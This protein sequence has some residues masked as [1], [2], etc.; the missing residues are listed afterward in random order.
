MKKITVLCFIGLVGAAAPFVTASAGVADLVKKCNSCHGEDGNS[1]YEEVPNIGG[2]SV[3]YI[4]DTMVAYQNNERPGKKF[5]PDDG[6][7]SDMNAVAEK[8][9]EAD[10][11]ALA[12]HYAAKPFVPHLQQVDAEMAAKGQKTFK[13]LCEKCHS[14]GGTVAD[15][16]SGIL[17]G[18]WKKYLQHEF[19]L[20]DTQ[21][22][23]MAKKM[24]KRYEK[25]GK[26]DKLEIL[27]YLAGGKK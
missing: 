23:E 11:N 3:V 14:E 8:L 2:M 12:D 22:R 17:L 18:Q 21:K 24:R 26:E 6:E 15:D 10:I 13:K 4:H 5:K 20:F 25:L 9:S 16:D 19:E 27:E 1:K 7:E